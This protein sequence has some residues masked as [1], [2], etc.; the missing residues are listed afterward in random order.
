MET[1]A[2]AA[3]TDPD[4]A[5]MLMFSPAYSYDWGC[6]CCIKPPETVMS[7]PNTTQHAFWKLY[8]FEVLVPLD[9][10][11]TP[12]AKPP[13]PPLSPPPPPPVPSSPPPS[14]KLVLHTCDI[15]Y[16]GTDGSIYAKADDGSWLSLDNSGND[17]ERDRTDTYTV[18]NATTSM[19]IKSESDDGWCVDGATY[20]SVTV[21]L[22]GGVWLDKPCTSAM[23]GSQPCLNEFS[24][25]PTT[26]MSS[27]CAPSP[28][29]T[30]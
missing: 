3:A 7:D 17:R 18:P 24:F 21:E 28:S 12:P 26:G 10:P 9:P 19:T 8:S 27:F 5:A 23:Y 22:C 25:D 30:R 20:G 13:P 4:C 11:S 14:P 6:M 1:C 15:P 2:L 16:A 29:P